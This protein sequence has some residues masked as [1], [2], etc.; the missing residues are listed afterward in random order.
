MAEKDIGNDNVLGA[1]CH[2][3]V[4][5]GILVPLIVYLLKGKE[6]KELGFQAKQALA[7]QLL[8]TVIAFLGAIAITIMSFIFFS[9][10]DSIGGILVILMWL[11]YSVVLLASVILSL[12]A[13][14]KTYSKVSYEYPLI[15]KRLR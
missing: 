14:W 3:P 7:Y 2:F 12:L 10:S 15:G 6:N 8:M 4:I 5:G 13:A 1:Y 11:I 9:I